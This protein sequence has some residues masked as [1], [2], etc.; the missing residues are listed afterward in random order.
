MRLAKPRIC[1]MIRPPQAHPLVVPGFRS[2]AWPCDLVQE[3]LVMTLRRK[4]WWQSPDGLGG[5]SVRRASAAQ[6]LPALSTR[7]QYPP[8]FQGYRRT[9][10]WIKFLAG[11]WDPPDCGCDDKAPACI[12]V[13]GLS[14]GPSRASALERPTSVVHRRTT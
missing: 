6:T 3:E 9:A 1:F 2:L 8:R 13:S 7:S 12:G 14:Q 10:V 5:R 4:T 11:G